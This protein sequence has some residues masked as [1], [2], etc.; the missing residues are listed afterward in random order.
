MLCLS[1][2]ELNSRWVPLTHDNRY[3]RQKVTKIKYIQDAPSS[4]PFSGNVSE[5]R[6]LRYPKILT[7]RKSR[8]F[9][10]YMLCNSIELVKTVKD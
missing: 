1:G 7:A 2:F 10:A 4:L 6:R 8:T 5:E 3:K 9:T